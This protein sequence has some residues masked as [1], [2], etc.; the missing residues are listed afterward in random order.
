MAEYIPS[1][2]EWVRDQVELYERSGGTEGTTLRDTGLPVIIVTHTGNKTGAIRKTPLMRVKDGANYV[3]IGSMGGAPGRGG[4]FAIERADGRTERLP[5]KQQGIT[6][7]PGDR[8]IMRTS[9]GGGLG[10]PFERDPDLVA[11]DVAE[12][13]VTVQGARDDYGVDVGP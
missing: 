3:L 8:F 1:P 10:D 2:R 11:A 13:R 6:V 4:W 9:G 7:G 5:T 12:G